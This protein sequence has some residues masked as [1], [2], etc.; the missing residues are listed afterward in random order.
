MDAQKAGLDALWCYSLD[1]TPN[2][3]GGIQDCWSCASVLS[4]VNAIGAQFLDLIRLGADPMAVGGI[5]TWRPPRKVGGIPRVSTRFSLSVGNEQ[6]D[7]GGDGRTR[8]AR[9]NYHARTKTGGY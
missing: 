4:A 9:P 6:A 2:Y 5:N 7:A 1:G 3:I 8:L